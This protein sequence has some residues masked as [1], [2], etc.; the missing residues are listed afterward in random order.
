MDGASPRDVIDRLVAATL[1]MRHRGAEAETLLLRLAADAEPAVAVL[2]GGRLAEINRDRLKPLLDRLTASSDSGLRQLGARVLAELRTPEAVAQLG[3][4]LDDP[5]REVR[6]FVRESLVRLAV[7]PA[8][9]EPVQQAAMRVLNGKGRAGTSRQRWSLGRSNINQPLIGS[10]NCWTPVPARFAS[11]P[12]GLCAPGRPC[13][14]GRHPG[15]GPSRD[16]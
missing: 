1:L 13:H 2:A 3:P 7:A 12:P 5:H 10:Y 16:E 14:C 15:T 11:P 9:A 4:L 8:L 6:V